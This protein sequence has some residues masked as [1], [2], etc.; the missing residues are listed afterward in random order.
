M[1]EQKTVDRA[2]LLAILDAELSEK[3]WAAEVKAFA[4]ERGWLVC[5]V[6][7]SAVR[8]GRTSGEIGY[9]WISPTEGDVGLPD[10]VFA[11]GGTVIL[12]ELKSEKGRFRPGQE[13][14]IRESGG[15]CWRPKDRQAMRE[16]LK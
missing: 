8:A 11:R 12:V 6:L 16:A 3:D 5:H 4:K 10:W 15:Y 2:E 13:E 7:P 9:K 1:S 14:W